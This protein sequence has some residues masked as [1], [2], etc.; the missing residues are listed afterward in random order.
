MDLSAAQELWLHPNNLSHP[1]HILTAVIPTNAA[2]ETQVEL[3]EP[4]VVNR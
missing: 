2:S 3:W 1:N 4:L